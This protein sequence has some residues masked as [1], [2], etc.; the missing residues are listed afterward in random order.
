MKQFRNYFGVAL[1]AI[2]AT[3][4]LSSCEQIKSFFSSPS[5]TVKKYFKAL[6][7]YDKDALKECFAEDEDVDGLPSADELKE[8][9]KAKVKFALK[10][11][12]NEEVDDDEATVECV[13]EVSVKKKKA[14][15]NMTIT[16]S[17]EDG[18]WLITDAE[19]DE[20]F[21]EEF[22]EVIVEAM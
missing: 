5:S 9:K 10:K 15:G 18:G 19:F 3:C 20:D 2:F 16:L 7:E 14:K 22:M 8:L 6:G 21:Q 11:I 1:M 13:V 4:L 17:K 12:E